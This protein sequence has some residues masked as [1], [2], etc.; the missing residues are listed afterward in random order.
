LINVFILGESLGDTGRKRL[1][2]SAD[3]GRHPVYR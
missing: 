1:R 3:C 2:L